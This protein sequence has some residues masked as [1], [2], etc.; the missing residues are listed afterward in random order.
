MSCGLAHV[1]TSP[2]VGVEN[3]KLVVVMLA[4]IKNLSG[5]VYLGPLFQ[6]TKHVPAAQDCS[7]HCELCWFRVFRLKVI[8]VDN[9]SCVISFE[10]KV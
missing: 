7:L 10:I 8:H 4:S 9:Y 2:Q 5:Q 3:Q 6:P 1:F